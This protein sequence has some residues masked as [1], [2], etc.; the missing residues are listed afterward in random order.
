MCQFPH[1]YANTI[2]TL[3]YVHP[4]LARMGRGEGVFVLLDFKWKIMNLYLYWLFL[5]LYV[6]DLP[7]HI[8]L[9]HLVDIKVIKLA[10]SNHGAK[11][12]PP[13]PTWHCSSL[14][15]LHLKNCLAHS[16]QALNKYVKYWANKCL[17]TLRCFCQ[18][19]VVL[20]SNS[21]NICLYGFC[22][23]SYAQNSSS[24]FKT[25]KMFTHFF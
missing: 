10:K 5:F 12:P 9:A 3:Y 16:K 2:L 24:R 4:N 22:L 17:L 18:L 19:Q 23:Y 7:I 21:N 14:D 1:S 13:P 11:L 6:C 25:G 15:T 20:C 8:S